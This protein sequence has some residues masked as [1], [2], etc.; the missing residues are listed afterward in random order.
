MEE[1]GSDLEEAAG[2]GKLL[3]ISASVDAGRRFAWIALLGLAR[4]LGGLFG[5]G[6]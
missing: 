5:F 3:W 4:S 2:G 6:F 1:G